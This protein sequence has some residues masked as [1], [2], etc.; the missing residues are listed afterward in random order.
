MLLL[1]LMTL[2]VS[3]CFFDPVQRIVTAYGPGF[4]DWQW[5]LATLPFAFEGLA[6]GP[7]FE[8]DLCDFNVKIKI[9][10]L[11]N[12]SE[13]A[14]PELMKKLADIFH[15]VVPISGLGQTMNG[16]TYR[17]VLCYR[18]GVPLF[19]IL[20]PCSACSRV[21]ARDIYE[22][23][24]VSCAGI[25]GI[26]DRHNIVRDTLIDIC[27]RSQISAGKEVDIKLSDGHD[28]PLHPADILLYSWDGG[29]DVCVD[30]TGS[31]PLTQTRM[32]NFVPSH[33]KIDATKRKRVKYEAKC[34]NIGYGF[35]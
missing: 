24:V 11:S 9:D 10:L 2:S 35:S 4:G 16:R 30:L 26:K 31:S 22:Y 7:A 12:P 20:K 1:R 33:A 32:A 27:F 25:V 8:D 29:L 5:K 18:L 19:S 3:Y 6:S 14:A 28:K 34:A 21:F 17:C 23:H 15:V 13:I